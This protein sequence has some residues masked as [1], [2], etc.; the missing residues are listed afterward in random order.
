[1]T[2]PF[3][4]LKKSWIG[5]VELLLLKMYIQTDMEKKG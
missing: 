2:I 4:G 3:W 5:L 1:M